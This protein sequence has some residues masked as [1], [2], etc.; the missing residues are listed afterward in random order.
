MEKQKVIRYY[1]T[2][3]NPTTLGYP[4]Y[5]F[6]NILFYN[7][8]DQDE[9][10]FIAFLKTNSNIVYAAK[11]TG[12]WDFTI[13]ICAKNL[14]QFDEIMTQI[15]T[16]FSKIIKEYDS[17]SIIQEYKFDYMVDLI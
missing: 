3:L 7:F 15:R 16:K 13:C 9:K 14:K 8:E 17:S 4:I 10:F 1:H 2:L 6:V 11:T 12:K 5:S